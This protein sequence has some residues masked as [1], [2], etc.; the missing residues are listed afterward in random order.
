M[1]T[2]SII[3]SSTSQIQPHL[4]IFP[5]F[6][7]P[8]PKWPNMIC[9]AIMHIEHSL[10]CGRPARATTLKKTDSPSPT[11]HQLSIAPQLRAGSLFPMLEH[12]DDRSCVGHVQAATTAV[13]PWVQWSVMARKSLWHLD[14]HNPIATRTI[15]LPP[16]L[17][18]LLSLG[19][20]A[21][22][23]TVVLSVAEQSSHLFS[24]FAQWWVS[25]L[26]A[27]CCTKKLLWWGL[28]AAL[29]YEYRDLNLEGIWQND[30]HRL[31]PGPMRSLNMGFWP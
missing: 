12:W 9:A 28:R 7:S 4:C 5:K 1:H 26:A 31:N 10:E 16:L 2:I 13:S 24:A 19:L 3:Y 21:Q 20:G 8:F 17:Q 15:F 14:P 11:S 18:C 27:I 6:L 25:V 23:W 30:S 29:M 22:V